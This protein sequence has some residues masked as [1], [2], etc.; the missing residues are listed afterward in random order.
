MTEGAYGDDQAGDPAGGV[1]PRMALSLGLL[2]S[3]VT[4][5]SF[6]F[7]LWTLSGVLSIPF[8]GGTHIDIPG[9]MVIAAFLYAVL[10][11][12]LTQK[13]GSPLV[14]LLFNHQR[15]EADFRFS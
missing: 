7:I 5:I 8:F 14:S 11:T 13:I 2:N 3:T 10:G 15:Y 4:L 6:L 9:Y 12:Y 1:A